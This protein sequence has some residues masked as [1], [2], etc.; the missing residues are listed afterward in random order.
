MN[1]NFN[2]FFKNI[3][4]RRRRRRERG[5]G[6]RGRGRG[7]SNSSQALISGARENAQIQ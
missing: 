4:K 3:R 2:K 1:K 7:R 5:R 6:R